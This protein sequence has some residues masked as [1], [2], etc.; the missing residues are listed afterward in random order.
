MDNKK[1]QICTEVDAI[2]DVLFSISD[3]LK[4]NPETA[5]LEKKA[6]QFLSARLEDHGFEVEKGVG[7]LETAFM[8]RPRGQTPKRPAVA[9]L[10]EYDALPKIGHG[11]GHNLIAAAGVGAAVAL[12]RTL[13]KD[14]GG[15]AL[16]GTPAEEGGGGKVRLVEARIFDGIDAAMMFHPKDA[17]LPGRDNLGRVTVKIEFIGK[18]AHA[19]GSPDRGLNALDAMVLAYTAM[20]SI[21]QHLRPDGRIHGII[22]HGGDAPNVIPDYTAGLFYV[23]AAGLKYRDE[24]FERVRGCAEG[25]ARATGTEARVE[26]VPP[27]LDPI[28]RN[29]PLE[30]AFRNNMALLGVPVDADDG[31]KGSSDIGNLSQYLP[32]IHPYLKI[33]EPG[34]PGHSAAFREATASPR[35]RQAMLNAAKLL[36]LTAYDY[37]TDDR[38]RQ[39]VSVDFKSD[40]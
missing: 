4:E 22:T 31:R 24:L 28:K 39:K 9:F 1:K 15:V 7:N 30:E 21:R 34:V 16:V 12:S 35:G 20:N 10:A 32:A 18:A 5:Y 6:C 23:R 11:C 8:A 33:V 25:A 3:Y 26:I 17:N 14:A 40:D 19:S 29:L 36:A 2:A 27:T 37:L 38:L 13:G